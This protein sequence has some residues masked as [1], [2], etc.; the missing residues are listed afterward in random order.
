VLKVAQ[1]SQ[2]L[3]IYIYVCRNIGPREAVAA[4]QKLLCE[5]QKAKSSSPTA[6]ARAGASSH[7]ETGKIQD[8]QYKANS[9]VSLNVVAN[10]DIL[11]LRGRTSAVA[12]AKALLRKID[13]KSQTPP[14]IS[15]AK[16][17]KEEIFLLKSLRA[18]ATLKTLKLMLEGTK[19]GAPHMEVD[20]VRDAIIVKGA[21]QQIENVRLILKALGE[22][23][24]ETE[25]K[26]QPRSP[27]N[28]G[29]YPSPRQDIGRD[30]AQAGGFRRK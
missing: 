30:T 22:S 1:G 19:D 16:K 26:K 25:Q 14:D 11:V 4:V 6:D 2:N 17:P 7:P 23:G 5:Q 13:V 9:E 12:E 18:S 3:P 10:S 8:P 15:K 27:D 21:A 29:D 28:G 20:G 24:S